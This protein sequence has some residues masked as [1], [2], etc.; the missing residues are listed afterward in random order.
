MDLNFTEQ[1]L[2]FRAEIR[3]WVAQNLPQAGS[4]AAD[5]ARA[6]GATRSMGGPG[7]TGGMSGANKSG[8]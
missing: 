8:S 7:G 3:E 2:A 4:K 5:S 1:E 6:G